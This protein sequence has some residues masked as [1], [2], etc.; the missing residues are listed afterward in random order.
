[1]SVLMSDDF[2]LDAE[3]YD[4]FRM[5]QGLVGPYYTP[6]VDDAGNLSWTNNGGLANPESVNI[7]GRGLTIVGIVE[8]VSEL[9]QTAD[10]Y[11]TYLVG[12]EAPYEGYIYSN[13]TWV[14]IGI[15]GRGEQGIPGVS[16]TVEVT[17]I[18][19]GHQ[20]EITDAEGTS[21]FNVMDG[22]DGVGVPSG[23]QAGYVLAKATNADYDTEW[24]EVEAGG[25]T[26]QSVN[27]VLPDQNGNITLT[28]DDIGTDETG[29]TIQDMVDNYVHVGTSAPTDSS[30]KLWLDTDEPGMSAVSSVNGMTGTVVLDTVPMTLLWTNASPTSD[31]AA[32]T[33]QI[34]YSDYDLIL[35]VIKSNTT[36]VAYFTNISEAVSGRKGFINKFST[37]TISGT[38]VATGIERQFE[39]TAS[40]IDYTRAFNYTGNT[41]V[42]N[43]MIP[44]K[45]YGIKVDYS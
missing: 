28:A 17:S 13:G 22:A 40:G 32:Q 37:T 11:V 1:M 3:Q 25:G 21:T 34:D 41:T 31:F 44:Y 6:S 35:M 26:V 9:P 36:S 30:V 5:W 23:G 4:E 38:T 12:E 8:D 42:N 33:V 27:E 14:D 19:G 29:V 43:E 10:D 18:T 7:Q 2:I 45:I 39:Y 15:V 20:V 24:I 16:P